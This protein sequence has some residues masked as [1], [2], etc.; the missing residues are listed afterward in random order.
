MTNSLPY[1]AHDL[2]GNDA[3]R[4]GQ[5]G[6]VRFGA[7]HCG[8]L[9]VLIAVEP[10]HHQL[11]PDGVEDPVRRDAGLTVPGDLSVVGFDD[12]YL[13]VWTNPPL[14]AVR[15]PLQEMG[16]LAFRTLMRLRPGDPPES[17]HVEMATQ[18]IPRSSTAPPRNGHR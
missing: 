4:V 6:L 7:L 15:Q 10:Q 14:T 12:T 2:R 9:D 18:L 13:A 5:V 11:W 3:N 8:V 1:S 17:H 16:E